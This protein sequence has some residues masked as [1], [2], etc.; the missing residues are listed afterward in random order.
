VAKSTLTRFRGS[1]YGN[2]AVKLPDHNLVVKFGR[3]ISSHEAKNQ[4]KAYITI[5]PDIVMVP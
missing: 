3:H 5:G 2:Q 1:K 4:Q